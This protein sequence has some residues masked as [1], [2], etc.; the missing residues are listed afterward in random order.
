L[1]L[2]RESLSE[3]VEVLRERRSTCQHDSSWPQ[4]AKRPPPIHK[5]TSIYWQSCGPKAE[6]L[7]KTRKGL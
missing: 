6:Q 7:D 5:Y 4:S 2:G 3:T 1:F